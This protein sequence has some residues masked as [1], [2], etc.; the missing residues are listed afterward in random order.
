MMRQL[1]ADRDPVFREQLA[2]REHVTTQAV[3]DLFGA[4]VDEVGL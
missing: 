3:V 1:R 4:V 2:L